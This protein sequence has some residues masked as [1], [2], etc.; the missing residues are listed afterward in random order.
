MTKP[1]WPYPSEWSEWNEWLAAGLHA[2]S[3][4]RQDRENPSPRRSWDTL[5]HV[6]PARR[7]SQAPPEPREPPVQAGSTSV[8]CPLNRRCK[9]PVE[10]PR[11]RAS[12]ASLRTPGAL[13]ET[14]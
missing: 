7:T 1:N 9:P 5:D 12:G 3:R 13:T 6:S 11:R 14:H 4:S 10:S 2:G 8:R